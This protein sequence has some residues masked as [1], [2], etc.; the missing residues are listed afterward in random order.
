MHRLAL[1]WAFTSCWGNTQDTRHKKL[2]LRY[3]DGTLAFTY[4]Q[5]HA[6]VLT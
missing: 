5:K 4:S 6:K 3:L 2:M 1:A